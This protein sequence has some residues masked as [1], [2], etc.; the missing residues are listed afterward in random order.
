MGVILAIV[1]AVV[2][3]TM[4]AKPASASV[5]VDR[6]CLG[7]A[8][9]PESRTTYDAGTQ[10]R[11]Y[12][13]VYCG[14]NSRKVEVGIQLWEDDYGI[15]MS[16]DDFVRG[17]S[18]TATV[19]DGKNRYFANPFGWCNEE[20]ATEELYT[21]MHYRYVYSNGSKSDWSPWDR[22]NGYKEVWCTG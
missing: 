17:T 9:M 22:T 3:M 16:G 1:V 5:Q 10:A 12:G 7:S 15:G 19:G 20:T 4:V 18:I 2:A 21:R 14:Y 8:E 13:Y 11:G 6:Y